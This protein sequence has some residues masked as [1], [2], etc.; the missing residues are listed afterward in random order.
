MAKFVGKLF[1]P[2]TLR[3]VPADNVSV[4]PNEPRSAV[5]VE[6]S[7][8][9]LVIVRSAVITRLP[10]ADAEP[11]DLL[12][13]KLL[14]VVGSI[15]WVPVPLK[16]FVP[17]ME[18]NV[19]ARFQFPPTVRVELLLSVADVF[20]DAFPFT[21]KGALRTQVP[22]VET[23]KAPVTVAELDKVAVPPALLTDRL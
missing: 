13:V 14:N 2:A 6:R 23:E 1:V 21:V 10:F 17:P 20:I 12:I 3:V 4:P 22:P 11:E 9:P 7:N 5:Y 16:T 19:P 18:L 8:V 15:V